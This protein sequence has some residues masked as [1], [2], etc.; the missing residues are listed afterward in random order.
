MDAIER[1]AAM[2]SEFPGV[3]PRQARRFVY[4]LLRKNR[5]FALELAKIIPT[6]SSS[7]RVCERCFRYHEASGGGVC[8]I[9]QNPERD[10]GTLMVVARDADLEGVERAQAFRGRYL[11]LGGTVPVLEKDPER[12]VRLRELV[13]RVESDPALAEVV[14][15]TNA[16]PEGDYTAGLVREALEPLAAARGL[17]VTILGRGLSTGSELEYA[18]PDTVRAALR[19]RA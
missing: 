8:R 2:F 10:P 6:L 14:V 1:L 15:A 7:V 4:F 13:A 16:T 5:A 18:D 11:V 12:L 17:K 9:C 3:G 19:G